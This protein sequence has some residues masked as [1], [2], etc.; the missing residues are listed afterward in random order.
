MNDTEL[1][2]SKSSIKRMY[3]TDGEE[4]TLAINK[5]EDDLAYA[6]KATLIFDRSHTN[7]AWDA[8]VINK[9]SD[10]RNIS[11]ISAQL[12]AKRDALM[13]ARHEYHKKNARAAQAMEQA[14]LCES[15][16]AA[17]KIVLMTE[18]H[19]LRAEVVTMEEAVMGCTKDIGT[20]T[21]RY[22]EIEKR[23]IEKHGR[24]DEEICE[25]EEIEYWL[26]TAC[27]QSLRDIRQFNHITKGEQEFLENMGLEPFAVAAEHR[28]FLESL[29]KKIVTGITVSGK[30]LDDYVQRF[31]IKYKDSYDA[32]LIRKGLTPGV[33]TEHLFIEE[34]K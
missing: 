25:L 5:A 22:K 15:G 34:S 19:R 26:K 23:I 30:E 6:G 4:V 11:V 20:L 17:D 9:D 24:F 21:A 28:A 2:V 14:E 27:R 32:K 10:C 8:H 7:F 3:P 31:Y 18:A 1:S 12:K 13:N 29:A 16:R 33:N